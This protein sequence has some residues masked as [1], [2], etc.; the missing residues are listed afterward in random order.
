MVYE[1]LSE[2]AENAKTGRDICKQL[3]IN[4]RDLTA[5]IEQERRAGYP[6]CASTGAN[7]GYFLAANKGEML[8]YCAALNHR[9][10][11]IHRTRRACIDTIEQLPGDVING[12]NESNQ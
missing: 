11:E 6:I 3:N 7:P 12:T 4:I 8:E 1:L 2:G 10:E 5:T 9:A